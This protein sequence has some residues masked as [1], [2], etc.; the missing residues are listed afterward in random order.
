MAFTGAIIQ[1]ATNNFYLGILGVAVHA[2]IAYKLGDMFGKVTDEY[3]GLEGISI[4]HGSLSLH[5]YLCSTNRRFN[6]KDS[7]NKQN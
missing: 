5:G 4:P 3:F 7:G 1:V 6:R 2:A